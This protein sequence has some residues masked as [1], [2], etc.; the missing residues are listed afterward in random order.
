[1]TTLSIN[2]IKGIKMK[3]KLLAF[4]S[5]AAVSNITF[6]YDNMPYGCSHK[7]HIDY[8]DQSNNLAGSI[9]A[10][11]NSAGGAL[12]NQWNYTDWAAFI[13]NVNSLIN[14]S[15][16]IKIS[17]P[18]YVIQ[19]EPLRFKADLPY[20]PNN[21]LRSVNFGSSEY[22]S[23][24]KKKS[25]WDA[26][27]YANLSLDYTYGEALVWSVYSDDIC[28]TKSV[29]VQKQPQ[30]AKVSLGKYGNQIDVSVT[31]SVDKYSKA[32]IKNQS[33]Q[34]KFRY[35]SE[36]GEFNTSNWVN[37]GLNSNNY[38]T[39]LTTQYAGIFNV[40]AYI[41]DGTY[42]RSVNLGKVEV[43]GETHRPCPTCHP[44]A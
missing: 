8:S 26:N 2:I 30:I 23:K 6:A 22:A 15:S 41:N 39:R 20:E 25:N 13:Y 19:G 1:M 28:S 44:D 3:T 35:V 27:A 29:M 18:D 11:F 38:S 12:N 10:G 14:G 17:G 24:V 42:T 31:Y 36:E 9:E 7:K 37:V 21:F 5:L 34:I 32:K 43:G 4:L 33:P 40:T 16:D